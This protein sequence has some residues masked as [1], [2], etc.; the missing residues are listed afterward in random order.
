M[1]LTS[2]VWLKI[3]IKNKRIPLKALANAFLNVPPSGRDFHLAVRN[4]RF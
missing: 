3:K 4:A 2:L 1:F